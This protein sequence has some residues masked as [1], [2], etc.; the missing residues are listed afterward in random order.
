[1]TID[2][3]T[4]TLAKGAHKQESGEACL[5]EWVSIFAGEPFSDS[6]ACTDPVIASYARTLN[7]YMPDDQ[8]QRL[9]AYIPL[10]V[11]ASN[12]VSPQARAYMC[13]DRAVRVFAPIALRAAQLA[14]EAK[15]LESLPPV[16]DAESA[17]SAAS[18]AWAA[19]A[20]SAAWDEAIQ[21][22]DDLI[23]ARPSGEGGE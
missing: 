23:E 5:M 12:G 15:K 8:R 21:L 11:K 7:D 3:E 22:L 10:L 9:R 17:E 20:A 18:A 2:L 16:V 4:I 13:A 14:D 1:M 6:P 19:W